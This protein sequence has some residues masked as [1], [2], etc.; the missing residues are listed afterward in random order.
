MSQD[1][2]ERVLGRLITDERFRTRV[3]DSLE[4]ASLQEGYLLTKAEQH[5]L[6]GLKMHDITELAALLDPGL[7]RARSVPK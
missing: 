6:S 2:V 3:I 7:C 4:V 5:L 1:A